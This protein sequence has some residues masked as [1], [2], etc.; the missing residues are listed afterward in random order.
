VQTY[1]ERLSAPLTWWITALA[2]AFIWGWVFRIATNWP[3]AI[4]VAVCVA[5]AAFAAVWRYGSMTITVDSD[6]LRVGRAFVGTEHIG[7]VTPLDR[8]G[9]R[10]TLGPGANARAYLATRPYLDHGVVVTIDD[11]TDPTPYWLVSSRHPAAFAAAL[12]SDEAPPSKAVNDTNG[13]ASR[14]EEA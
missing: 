3:I 4:V 1:R 13:D 6:G 2:F 14:G 10:N 12:T 8:A 9:Y 7:A 5:F 11:A